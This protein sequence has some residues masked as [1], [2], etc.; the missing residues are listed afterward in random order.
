VRLATFGALA[1][2]GVDRWA[3]LDRAAPTWRLIGLLVLALALAAAGPI[4]RRRSL[5]LAVV[6]VAAAV[7]ATF[8]IAGV[9][10]AWMVHA[11][12]AVTASAI[13]D[14]LSA[15]PS[16]AVPYTGLDEWVRLVIVLGAAVLLI[17]AAVMLALTAREP[18]GLRRA[19]AALPLLALA[20]IPSTIVHPRFPYLQGLILF[21]LLAGFVWGERIERSR[22]SGALAL[23]GVAGIVALVVAPALER[24]KPWFDYPALWGRLAVKSES[25][26]WSQGYGPIDWPR[27]GRT[28]LEVRAGR[29][30]Y[31]KAE[32]L[33]LFGG[34]GWV[35]GDVPGT[36]D[37][38]GTISRA[39]RARWTQTIQV[40]V[41][42]MVTTQV[43][44][45]GWAGP[46]S[47]LIKPFVAGQSPG[48]WS[49]TGQLGPGDSYTIRAYSPHPS[50]AELAGAGTAYPAA[51]LP[52]YLTIY[53]PGGA[54]LPGQIQQVVFAPFGS[55]RAAAY[56]PASADPGPVLRDSPY[57]SA[58]ALALRL[59]RGA[60][61]PLAYLRAVQGYLARGFTYDE[62]P[63]PSAY[64]LESFLFKTRAGYCQQFAGTMALLL[65]M[66]GVPA[67]V[68][69]GF[70][71]GSYDTVTRRWLV[72][73]LDAHAWVEAWFP[74]YGWVR[75]DPTP[76]AAPALGG[77]SPIS[78]S[79]GSAA[80]TPAPRPSG[81]GHGGAAPA[82]AATRTSGHTSGLG[83]ATPALAIG[84]LVLIGILGAV[85]LLTRPLP[86]GEP[87]LA[88]L[89]RAFARAGRPLGS[90]TTLLA[91]ERRLAGSPAAAAYVRGL[92]RARFAGELRGASRP[93]RRALRAQLRA[94][95]GP[96]GRLRALWALP[97]R[98]ARRGSA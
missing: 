83:G 52:G 33:D 6:L 24:H 98:R 54:Q 65:R 97:P 63:S 4:A 87:E 34:R 75:F 18:G 84:S 25:F 36:E 69:A 77:R 5:A 21:A 38:S 74:S 57:G 73:D 71:P 61:G 51:L 9:P 48:T 14:G 39:A 13:G 26:D 81:H 85:A 15:L 17:D 53:V 79:T 93:Q 12:V 90:D 19:G 27:R 72:S 31:W 56:G 91:L 7:V 1:A 29:P 37:P 35:L 58:Y 94:G 20:A 8:P 55:S 28:V 40:T 76:G 59:R 86:P 32:D 44:A 62:N 3:T 22:L 66:G 88:E 67:R 10:L 70:T 2:Y 95:L 23:C 43:I 96:L 60:A 30:E 50:D 68:A 47:Q 92:R 11:R 89:E 46:P 42:N 64:P 45:A 49:A 41:R 82:R 78:S 80:P 16:T